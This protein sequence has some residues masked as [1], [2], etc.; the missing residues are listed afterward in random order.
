MVIKDR[1]W[2]PSNSEKKKYTT[3]QIKP[4]K[5]IFARLNGKKIS[6]YK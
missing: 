3:Q 4:I 2:D 6:Q 1:E 5:L